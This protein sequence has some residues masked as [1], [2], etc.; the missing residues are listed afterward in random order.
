MYFYGQGTVINYAEASK[1]L[2]KSAG[3]G[4]KDA[5]KFLKQH[6]NVFGNLGLK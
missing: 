1:R 4:N 2:P 3:L 6:S 5:I